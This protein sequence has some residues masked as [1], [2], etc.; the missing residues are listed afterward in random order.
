MV[1]KIEAN[2]RYNL[3]K[4]NESLIVEIV[5]FAISYEKVPLRQVKNLQKLGLLEASSGSLRPEER[6]FLRYNFT[7]STI[8]HSGF[9][10]FDSA[11]RLILI[12]ERSP[13]EKETRIAVEK[14]AA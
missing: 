4:E 7:Q 2:R 13:K 10:G 6:W 3:H 12:D 14:K 11:W 9:L 5:F 8:I 1:E